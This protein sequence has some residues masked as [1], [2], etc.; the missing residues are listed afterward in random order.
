M[1]LLFT[2]SYRWEGM[3]SYKDFIRFNNNDF[4]VE[5]NDGEH[6]VD[7]SLLFPLEIGT[8]QDNKRLHVYEIK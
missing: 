5:D 4:I 6:N 2:I 3:Q 8:T 7:V 1:L